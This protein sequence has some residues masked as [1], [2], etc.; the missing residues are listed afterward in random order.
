MN[1]LK[2]N[3][4]GIN[5]WECMIVGD[6]EDYWYINWDLIKELRNIDVI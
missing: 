4:F 2:F 1:S 5:I 6:K 3:K